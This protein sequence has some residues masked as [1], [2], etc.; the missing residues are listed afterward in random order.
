MLR[1][2]LRMTLLGALLFA[3]VQSWRAVF[4]PD[5]D[6]MRNTIRITDRDIDQLRSEWISTYAGPPNDRELEVLI[7]S[8]IN[9][10]VLHL[11]ALALRLHRADPVVRMRL[12]QNMQFLG[13]G[14]AEEESSLY[15]RAIDL[16]MAHNDIVVR[17]RLIERM[18]AVIG[19]TVPEPSIEECRTYV[20]LHPEQFT[21][22]PKYKLRYVFEDEA[23]PHALRTGLFGA[24]RLRSSFGAATA[25]NLTGLA[26]GVWHGPFPRDRGHYRI[27]IEEII[28]GKPVPFEFSRDRARLALLRER[29]ARAVTETVREMRLRYVIEV[30]GVVTPGG[31]RS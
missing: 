28:P 18:N 7:E 2:I 12:V 24:K 3:G 5:A 13:D 20:D 17:R 15:E 26:P 30:S 19:A 23:G 21:S 31:R 27:R 11:E 25:E 10:E 1:P 8:A 4:L 29:R 9:D 22:S 14:D 16:G 6:T